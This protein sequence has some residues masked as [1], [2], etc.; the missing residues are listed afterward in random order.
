MKKQR[1]TIEIDGKE[2]KGVVTS[3]ETFGGLDVEVKGLVDD[4]G[5]KHDDLSWFLH[6][7]RLGEWRNYKIIALEP[8]EE[9]PLP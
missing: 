8:L 2:H 4:A 1:I 5:N 9:V 3:E 6:N 7:L